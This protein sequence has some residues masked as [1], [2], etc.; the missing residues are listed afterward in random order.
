MRNNTLTLSLIRWILLKELC[1][2]EDKIVIYNQKFLL[3][4]SK[5]MRIYIEPKAPPVIISS[6]N[7]MDINNI[8]QQDSNWMEEISI[9]IYSRDLEALQRKEEVVMAL[10]SIYSQQMQEKNS[11]KIFRN[12]RIIPVNEIEGAARLYRFDIE[13]RVQAWYSITKVAE[14][15]NSFNVQILAESD[16]FGPGRQLQEVEFVIPETNPTVPPVF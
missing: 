4:N 15:F 5:G 6:R 11:F 13:C 14:F 2:D 3:P 9:G 16:G 12:A 1:I 7:F 10:H 8:E